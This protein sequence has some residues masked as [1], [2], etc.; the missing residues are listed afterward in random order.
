M[1]RLQSVLQCHLHCTYAGTKLHVVL[2]F[3][4]GICPVRNAN[5]AKHR[6]LPSL[7]WVESWL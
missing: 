1:I 2:N 5:A 3:D 7:R 6:Q 4:P